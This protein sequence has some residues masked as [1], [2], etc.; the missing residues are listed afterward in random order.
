MVWEG[1]NMKN[2]IDAG[3]NKLSG[4]VLR[5]KTSHALSL[6]ATYINCPPEGR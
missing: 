4:S 3:R 2:Q 1:K 6:H 5:L